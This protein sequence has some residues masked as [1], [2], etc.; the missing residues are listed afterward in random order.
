MPLPLPPSADALPKRRRF[1]ASTP[2]DPALTATPEAEA[3]AFALP[4]ETAPALPDAPP[5][6][7]FHTAD[8]DEDIPL[9]TEIVPPPQALAIAPPLPAPQPAIPSGLLYQDLTVPVREALAAAPP[10]APV[11]PLSVDLARALEARLT[12]ALPDIMADAQAAALAVLRDRVERITQAAIE[13]AL[14]DLLHA[15]PPLPDE[16]PLP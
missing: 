3:P 2:A 15:R 14:A 13:G 10:A 6:F 1:L 12:A 7:H 8:E 11:V 4:P 9:L 5:P 16:A